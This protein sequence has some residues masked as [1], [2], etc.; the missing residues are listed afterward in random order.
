MVGMLMLH[1]THSYMHDKVKPRYENG[2]TD[3]VFLICP[4]SVFFFR[5]KG[6]YGSGENEERFTYTM[7]L[8]FVQC[9]IN[10]ICAR[11]G[12]YIKINSHRD[13]KR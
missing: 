7:A 6:K 12:N 11:G 3:G 13:F 4:S 1:M 10:A 2:Q 5:T 8:I 9:I